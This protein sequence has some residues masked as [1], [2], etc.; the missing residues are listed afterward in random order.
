MIEKFLKSGG[1]ISVPYKEQLLDD[2]GRIELSTTRRGRT[3][4][5]YIW[6][7]EDFAKSKEF[8]IE[9]ID[10][11]LAYFQKHAYG[12]KN[13]GLEIQEAMKRM[14]ESDISRSI[15]D[16]EVKQY[17][18]AIKQIKK[19]KEKEGRLQLCTLI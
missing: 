10:E 2:M 8:P 16:A 14:G 19:E 17:M 12:S 11:A 15:S 13:I 6:Y 9:Q 18:K 1:I 4:R 5:V 7:T 3:D